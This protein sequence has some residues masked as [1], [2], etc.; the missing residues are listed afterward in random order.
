[1]TDPLIAERLRVT[2]LSAP[3]QDPVPMS[4]SQLNSRS[5]CLIEIEAGGL[6]GIG[7]SWI[8]YP[9]WAPAERLATLMEGVAPLLLGQDVSLPSSTLASLTKQLLPVARQWGAPGP[10]WQAISGVDLALWDLLGKAEGKSVAQ[11]LEPGRETRASV[12]AYAS[13]VGPTDVAE[14]CE[15]ALEIGLDAV[16]TKVGFGTARDL[17]TVSTARRAIGTDRPLF[18]DANQAWDLREAQQ[19][20]REVGEYD[21]AWLEEPLA[22]DQVDELKRLGES[23]GMR[24]ATGENIYGP[25]AFRQYIDSGALHV[26]QPDLAKSGGISIGHEIAQ[27]AA[28]AGVQ[29]AP[30]CYAGVV[31]IAASLQLG[32]AHP[33]ASWIELDIRPNPLRDELLL[34]PLECANGE[35]RVPVG[36]GH[37][38]ELDQETISRYATRT[39]ERIQNDFR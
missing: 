16:K 35:M 8:N 10:V 27:R 19:F 13:G 15:T 28:S 4:F 38:I 31:G 2:F 12:P 22:G 24:L 32:A 14:L 1:M 30:H 9:S 34:A 6:I 5:M 18:A 25:A 3:I 11:L 23:S 21:V 36:F 37:G 17:E 39:E 29:L 26:I 7:E 33:C 20:C